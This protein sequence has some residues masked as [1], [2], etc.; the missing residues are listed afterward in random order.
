[1][2]ENLK[3]EKLVRSAQVSAYV[4]C[5]KMHRRGT[6]TGSQRP[7][8]AGRTGE[9]RMRASTISGSGRPAALEAA[10]GLT[11]ASVTVQND[12]C[13]RAKRTR[14]RRLR[15]SI[16][17]KRPTRSPRQISHGSGIL[18]S[19][20]RIFILKV[21]RFEIM[22][23]RDCACCSRVGFPDPRPSCIPSAPFR[24]VRQLVIYIL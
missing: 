22:E 9:N 13:A 18:V 11:T 4:S 15:R 8:E 12:L 23:R 14:G 3:P 1:M 21:M 20:I 10:S 16:A 6:R 2:Y 7:M 5:V 17:T 24:H 19:C